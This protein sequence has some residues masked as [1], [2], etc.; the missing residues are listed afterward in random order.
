MSSNLIN[1]LDQ[2]LKKHKQLEIDLSQNIS[3]SEMTSKSKEYAQIT[4]LA[5]KITLYMQ[6]N[7]EIESSQAMIITEINNLEQNEYLE[8]K[9][10]IEDEINNLNQIN[11]TL[12]QEIKIMLIPK[13][14]ADEKNAIVEIR[15]GTG[16]D[17]ASLFAANLYNMYIAYANQQNY[18]YEIM[19]SSMTD[20]G[21]IK[22]II[23]LISG[24]NIFC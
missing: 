19:Q 10:L 23:L 21:G 1:T 3:V 4:P 15:A 22:E 7:R 16:G 11:K 8:L 24:K 13:D 14:D 2:I 5:E 12:L 17:E 20:L 6:N 18:K 9:Q